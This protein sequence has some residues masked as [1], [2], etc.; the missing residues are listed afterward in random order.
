MTR[1]SKCY[2]IKDLRHAAKKSLPGVMFDYIAGGAEDEITVRRNLESFQHYQFVP[3]VLKDVTHINL[4][5]TIQGVRSRL[6]IICAP[7]A[8]SRTFHYLGEKAV[9]K[10]AGQAGIPY[11][12]STV[13]TTSI[14]DIAKISNGVKFFQIY[15]WRNRQMVKDFI[16]RCRQ[17]QYQAIMLAVDFPTLGNRERD[18][19]NGH[20][21]LSEQR[22]KILAG[23]LMHP[24]WFYRYLTSAPLTMA[25]MVEFL[26]HGGDAAK[27]IDKVNELFDASITWQ[28]AAEIQKLWGGP[29]I[30]KGIQS[31]A[32][33]KLAVELGASGIVLSNHGGRQLDG[34]P[35][36]MDL[37]PAVKAAVNDSL[38]IYIDGGI[39]R[40][41]DVI[42]AIA[43]GA[44]ACLIGRPYLYGLAAGGEAGVSHA[45]NI[46]STE[47]TRVMQLIGC[48]SVSKLSV[49]Y[50][51]NIRQQA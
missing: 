23:A 44:T 10:A 27:T 4:T 31:V 26:P 24:K 8:M 13:A 32:D 18:L 25:N 22:L 2:A 6:P 36:A 45:L 35:P 30:L 29:F 48:D 1:L 39:R 46:F 14:E 15:A 49:D 33:A 37:L 7:T 41:S 47:M 16:S 21:H 20:G 3:R 19:R 40:G 42:K 34:A 5:T 50:V 28:D 9:A 11:T 38:E 12:L 43:L 51:E 17:S